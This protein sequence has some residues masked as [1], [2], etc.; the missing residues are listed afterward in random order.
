MK[1]LIKRLFK[2][3][4]KS[5]FDQKVNFIYDPRL[6]NLK[7]GPSLLKKLEEANLNLSKIKSFPK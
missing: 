4:K 7:P 3:K 5:L 6:D 2:R 1:K